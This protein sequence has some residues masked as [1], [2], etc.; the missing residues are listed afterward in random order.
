ME[1]VKPHCNSSKAAV[2]NISR[3]W[4]PQAEPL[5][6]PS[7]ERKYPTKKQINKNPSNRAQW[8]EYTTE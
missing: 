8:V 3:Q 4:Q 6:F 2:R 7:R 1:N 5:M